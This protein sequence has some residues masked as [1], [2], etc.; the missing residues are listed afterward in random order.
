MGGVEEVEKDWRSGGAR[1]ET[2]RKVDTGW[3]M[4]MRRRV[5]GG[6]GGGRGVGGRDGKKIKMEKRGKKVVVPE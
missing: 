2:E 3:Q 6:I 5:R 1:V 4:I